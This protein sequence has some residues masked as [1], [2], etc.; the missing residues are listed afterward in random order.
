[1]PNYANALAMKPPPRLPHLAAF[2]TFWREHPDEWVQQVAQF[3]TVTVG[4]QRYIRDVMLPRGAQ[5]EVNGD[6]LVDAAAFDRLSKP[7]VTVKKAEGYRIDTQHFPDKPPQIREYG[8]PAERRGS[9]AAVAWLP[10]AADFFSVDR[11]VTSERLIGQRW[12]GKSPPIKEALDRAMRR[13]GIAPLTEDY[14]QQMT[15]TVIKAQVAAGGVDTE[16]TRAQAERWCAM[17]C[18][19]VCDGLRATT[20]KSRNRATALDAGVDWKHKPL[21]KMSVD[22]YVF[23][24]G[25]FR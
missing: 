2:M 8:L 23:R 21:T 13:I 12:D 18:E 6:I 19:C 17:V 25:D 11:P 7:T 10:L 9:Y 4:E 3:K 24:Q 16:G 14:K 22:D 20:F 1:M 15:D 5:V